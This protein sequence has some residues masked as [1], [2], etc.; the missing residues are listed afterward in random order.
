MYIVDY[1]TADYPPGRLSDSIINTFLISRNKNTVFAAKM[2]R[3]GR[4]KVANKWENSSTNTLKLT[5]VE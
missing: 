3:N 1:V 5:K 4:Y 2:Q